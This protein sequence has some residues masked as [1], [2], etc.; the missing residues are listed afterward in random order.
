MKFKISYP[1]V[2]QN[3]GFTMKYILIIIITLCFVLS[4]NTCKT[5]KNKN[6]TN[7]ITNQKVEKFEHND[8]AKVPSD[9]EFN[10]DSSMWE[11]FNTKEIIAMIKEEFRKRKPDYKRVVDIC[12]IG[13]KKYP[14]QWK[15]TYWL[16]NCNMKRKNF[17][18]A[19]KNY[20]DAFSKI[21][22]YSK[23]KFKGDDAA[24]LHGS[25]AQ[26]YKRLNQYKKAIE[27]FKISAELALDK[28]TP[29]YNMAVCYYDIAREIKKREGKLT[30]DIKLYTKDAIKLLENALL[31]NIKKILIYYTLADISFFLED[32]PNAEKY[33]K[34]CIEL[35]PYDSYNYKKLA[36]SY[37]LMGKKELSEITYA[38]SN[39][40]EE[41]PDYE[42][43]I[44]HLDSVNWKANEELIVM[45]ISAKSQLLASKG[46]MNLALET[47]DKYIKEY[48]NIGELYV[49]KTVLEYASKDYK[50]AL[51]TCTQGLKKFPNNSRLLGRAA[52]AYW[53]LNNINKAE[54]YFNKALLIEPQNAPIREELANF[55]RKKEDEVSMKKA[56]MHQGILFYYKK[57]FEEVIF[58]FKGVKGNELGRIWEYY[59][60][61]G[62]TYKELGDFDRA[63]YFLKKANK[64]KS[65]YF[66]AVYELAKLYKE[67][68][69]KTNM[70]N[71]IDSFIRNNPNFSENK[72]LKKLK[73]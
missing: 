24:E 19:L 53:K 32:Y 16:G 65:D 40:W 21:K 3:K 23:D 6:D 58:A 7:N 66:E 59:Y 47:I 18:E 71:Q 22:Q 61:Y 17:K 29:L 62:L 48:P 70:K 68:G 41:P 57:Q 34:L 44:K 2:N 30:K 31:Y 8:I 60:Y 64:S 33:Y 36:E 73:F 26:A 67:I 51:K 37:L 55:Y 43:V 5:G 13:I 35:E 39:F 38:K 15:F 63:I 52:S 25:I 72:K 45:Y 42:S 12:K 49:N 56:R 10:N 27:N 46:K 20:E 9:E 69:D 14:K 11:N 54:E 28:G 1:Y 4:I 50:K